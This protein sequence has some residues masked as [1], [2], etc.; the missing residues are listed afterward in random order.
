MQEFKTTQKDQQEISY[1]LAGARKNGIIA[2]LVMSFSSL[3]SAMFLF[4]ANNL[5]QLTTQK[6]VGFKQIFSLIAVIISIYFYYKALKMISNLSGSN[7]LRSY[8]KFIT[9]CIFIIASIGVSVFIFL[10]ICQIQTKLY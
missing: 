7:A 10:H 9:S 5:P 8:Q 4:F 6:I 3:L 2:A 1:M